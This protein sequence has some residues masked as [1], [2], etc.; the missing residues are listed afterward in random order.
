MKLVVSLGISPRQSLKDW[1]ELA[2]QLERAGVDRIW[3]IDSQL[4]MKDVY[5]GLASAALSTTRIEF[6]PGVTN[7]FTRHPT[8]TGNAIA[9]IAELSE[10]RTLLGLGAGDSAVYG[11][12]HRPARVA[13]IE[14]VIRFFQDVLGGD[15]GEWQGREYRAAHVAAPTPIHLA[16]S[17][18]RMC[19]VAGALADGAIIMGPAQPDM[20]RRQVQWI[21]AGIEDAGR[22][23]SD[24][25]IYFVATTSPSSDLDQATSDVR[26]WATGQA[27]LLADFK[28][29]PPSLE[30]HR[31][32]F[33]AAKSHYD[34]SEHLSTHAG[35]QG[36]I[37]DDLV[38]T[39]AVAGQAGSCVERL[40]ALM[41]T[42]IDG[43]IFPLLGGGR[44]KRLDVLQDQVIPHLSGQKLTPQDERAEASD[45]GSRRA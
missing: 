30:G 18:R 45:P 42:G 16:V 41:A 20:L 14:E 2:G 43:L 15:V 29:L 31:N 19:T 27:R 10:G 28:Y 34:Y 33:L 9:A 21:Q 12:G 24:V 40:N 39:L 37:S 38:R 44:L 11:I 6:G 35:H 23:R 26:S 5:V 1:M 17:Q 7:P 8:V 25:E 3:L 36:L 13:E 32:E 4:A 22:R